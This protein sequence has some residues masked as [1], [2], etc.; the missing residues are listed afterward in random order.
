MA[1]AARPY[2]IL[3]YEI[4]TFKLVGGWSVQ[5]PAFNEETVSPQIWVLINYCFVT[6]DISN[7]VIVRKDLNQRN[8][9]FVSYIQILENAKL[10]S[11]VFR[12][13]FFTQR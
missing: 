13:L 1:V 2:L 11:Q 9:A 5:A 6:V 12:V 3:K 7:Q 4:R 10:R 8:F